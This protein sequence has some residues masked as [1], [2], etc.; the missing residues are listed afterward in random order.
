MKSIVYRL[1][2]YTYMHNSIFALLE[3][4]SDCVKNTQF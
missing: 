3:Y 2:I 4:D 1:Y